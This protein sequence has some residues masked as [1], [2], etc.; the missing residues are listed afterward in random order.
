[1][2]V[3][4]PTV[5]RPNT[6]AFIFGTLLFIAIAVV[7][8]Y[9]VKWAPYW[10]KAHLAAATHSIGPSMVSGTSAAPPA[11]GWA[12][13]W[14][15]TLAYFNAVWT[16]VVL[17]LLLGASIQVFVPRKWLLQLLGAANARSA[18]I[19]GAISLAGMMCTCCTAPI[20][21]GMRKQRTSMEG[22]LAFFLGNPL[23]N[24]A[25]L[26]FMGFVL[27]WQFAAIRLVSAV[28][29]IAVVVAVAHRFGAALPNTEVDAPS[30]D[31][32]PIERPDASVRTLSL[33]WLKEMW[34]EIVAILPGYIAIVLLLG[35]VRAFLF[36]PGL[37]LHTAGILPTALVAL[38]GTFFVVP[39][40]GEVPI[41]QALLAHGMSTSAAIALIVTL[42]AIS[43]PSL[44]IVRKVFP[45]KVLI[46]TF[47][48][49]FVG[50]GVIGSLASIFFH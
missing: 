14:Q 22:A 27:G 46:A 10:G 16:A 31:L 43:L 18:A 1:M 42:P 2:S 23:L 11:V 6:R 8:L 44:F 30:F 21:V 47:G 7:G 4:A 50:G 24:P 15:Y 29:L 28:L 34:N 26:I 39:T 48:I 45:R 19:A 35:A 17:A 33:A 9:I 41:V 25:V 49:I 20:V 37:T 5:S 40:A 32:A 3:S 13:A 12:A 38:A 36:P